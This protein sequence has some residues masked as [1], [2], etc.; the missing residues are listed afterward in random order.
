MKRIV[1]LLAIVAMSAGSMYAQTTWFDSNE[2]DN[3]ATWSG[4]CCEAQ[5]GSNTTDP[6]V[7]M[8][9]G[10]KYE[11]IGLSAGHLIRMDAGYVNFDS[12]MVYMYTS[13]SSNQ[14]PLIASDGTELTYEKVTK[15]GKNY[16]EAKWKNPGKFVGVL[17]LTVGDKA[18]LAENAANRDN[19]GKADVCQVDV[20]ASEEFGACGAPMPTDSVTL[21]I[22]STTF[23]R[24]GDLEYDYD[25]EMDAT[26]NVAGVTIHIP[27]SLIWGDDWEDGN[28]HDYYVETGMTVKVGGQTYALEY[29]SL[30]VKQNSVDTKKFDFHLDVIGANGTR[31]FGDWTSAFFAPNPLY[32][33]EPTTPTTINFVPTQAIYDTWVSAHQ[34]VIY[35]QKDDDFIQLNFVANKETS[36]TIVA[37]GTYTINDEGDLGTVRA[38]EGFKEGYANDESAYYIN[39][40][41]EEYGWNPE[42]AY[43]F[44]SGTVKVESSAQG[45]KITVNATSYYG[46]TVSAVYE[47]GLTDIDD[48]PT[49]VEELRTRGNG[50]RY[51]ILGIPCDESYHGVVIE[52]GRKMRVQ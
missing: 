33:K 4:I 26:D 8:S 38:S 23:A 43:F 35:L 37:L 21:N 50:T 25:Y 39:P 36:G 19:K 17:I 40:T 31:Y 48:L 27:I 45:I 47:G 1:I 18:T 7:H 28:K 22:S 34:I 44:K 2:L 51:T 32:S 11:T 20:Y 41:E 10:S 29:G 3:G 15:D 13:A 52:N 5:K 16:L 6:F 14:A 9:H 49:G 24:V 30:S 46:S 42:T 12:V